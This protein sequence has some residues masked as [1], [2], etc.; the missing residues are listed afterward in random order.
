MDLQGGQTCAEPRTQALS[1]LKTWRGLQRVKGRGLVP[2][3]LLYLR[4][5]R[6]FK[7]ELSD[8]K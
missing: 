7:A 2:S 3:L 4:P 1:P 5:L 8:L 6:R